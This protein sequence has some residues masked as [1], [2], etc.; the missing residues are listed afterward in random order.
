MSRLARGHAFRVAF[1]GALLSFSAAAVAQLP[2]AAGGQPLPTLAPMLAEV[3]PAVVNIAVIARTPEENPLFADPFFR[4]FFDLPDRPPRG[5]QA[6]GS[7]VIVD[8]AAGL[9]ITNHHVVKDAQEIFV[10][11]KDRRVLKAQVVG[12]D[13]GTDVAV[14]RISPER[15]TAAKWGDSEALNVGDFVVAIGNPFG[16]GQTVTSGIVSA[17]GRTGLSIEGYEE[18]IQTDASINPGNSGGALVNLRGELVGINTAIIGPAG[19][20]VGI[21]F[22]VPA[23]MAR[24]VMDQILRFGEVR[25]GKLGVT[26]QDVT[27][28][29]AA[30]LGLGVSEGALVAQVERGSGAERAGLRPRD[31]V[32]TVNRRRIQSSSELRNRVG[33]IPVGEEVELGVLRGGRQ[34]RVRARVGELYQ[35]TRVTGET[36]PQ[37]AGAR[38]ANVEPGK[39]MH[40]QI[41]AVVVTAV[42]SESAAFRNGL[43]SGDLIVGVNRARVRNV[44]EL[45]AAMRAAERPVRIT[46]VRGEYRITLV[47]R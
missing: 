9:V 11:L 17:L 7:G 30:K 20:N 37:L 15:L 2:A 8:A 46:L 12:V 5:E 24:A 35:V 26:T 47:I 22:A 28:D 34:I 32:T 42:D 44:T 41:E 40:G 43:R 27:P 1:L 23:H 21:G 13:P 38:V 14:L 6:A 39:P 16:I 10:G 25:R 3:T 33:L 19:G 4:R 18:F 31:V 45:I 29:V 36:I